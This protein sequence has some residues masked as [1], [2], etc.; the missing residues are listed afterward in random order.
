MEVKNFMCPI[1]NGNSVI[2]NNISIISYPAIRH[3]N[4]RLIIHKELLIS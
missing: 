4:F 1:I 2:V 3:F